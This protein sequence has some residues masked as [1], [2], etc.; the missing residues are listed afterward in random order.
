M[1]VNLF[2]MNVH[3]YFVTFTSFFLPA[4]IYIFCHFFLSAL[5]LFFFIENSE[6]FNQKG[7][8]VQ[9]TIKNTDRKGNL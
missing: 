9:I 6:L 4:Y 1:H 2:R 3:M 8:M 5:L 7:C